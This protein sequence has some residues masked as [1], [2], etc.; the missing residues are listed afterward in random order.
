MLTQQSV[1]QILRSDEVIGWSLVTSP[2]A[3][4]VAMN[5]W[6]RTIETAPFAINPSA[7]RVLM[8]E[9]VLSPPRERATEKK[10]KKLKRNERSTEYGRRNHEDGFQQPAGSLGCCPR[11]PPHGSPHR[12]GCLAV[13]A[14]N[15][16]IGCRET[17]MTVHSHTLF[18]SY[19]PAMVANH[20][21]ADVLTAFAQDTTRHGQTASQD[22]R[23]RLGAGR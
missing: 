8:W 12:N 3:T 21:P 1:H 18:Q 17:R 22:V 4:R 2:D 6:R 5:L 19:R 15:N 13:C 14:T 9:R 7:S 10:A 23:T 11:A 16:N 20:A